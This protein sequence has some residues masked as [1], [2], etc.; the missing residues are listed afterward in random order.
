MI[1]KAGDVTQT[2]GQSSVG[3]NILGQGRGRGRGRGR[4][5]NVS[6]T[7]GGGHANQNTPQAR[8]YALTRE[9]A[10]TDPGV[11]SGKISI[12]DLDFH[13]LI[14]PGSTHSFMSLE[15][16]SQ[17]NIKNELL[18]YDLCV[19]MPAGGKIIVDKVCRACP[20]VVSSVML[21]ADLILMDFK[22]FDII[23]GMDW[24][25]KHHAILD[26][27]TKEMVIQSLEHPKVTFVGER[28]S[29]P[30]CL[31]LAVQAFRL[32][33]EGCDAFLACV[34]DTNITTPK[35]ED[36]AIVREFPDIF[37]MICLDCHHI[38]KLILL[39]RPCQE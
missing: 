29:I 22:E 12:C 14:D 6:L 1:G 16:A 37:L 8:V 4:G 25:A 20:V 36:I 10:P 28:K 3:E 35:L 23:L 15:T 27:Y 13:V 33:K 7:T 18:G 17:V 30:T 2:V 11:I 9:E 38:D 24:L 26:C 19:L 5:D 34:V 21:P 32:I 31:I 39:L